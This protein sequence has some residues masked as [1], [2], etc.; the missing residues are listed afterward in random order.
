MDGPR[1]LSRWVKYV[2][3]RKTNT[4]YV[5]CSLQFNS[6]FQSYLTLWPH[7]LQYVRF[8]CP[9]WTP[10]PCSNS[11]PLSQ[12]WH[13]TTSSS[14]DPFFSHLQSFPASGSFQMS[15]LFASGGQRNG[16]SASA[17]DL[18]MNI[19]DWFPLGWTGWI[20]LQSKGLSR[21]Q[22][23]FSTPQFK[24]INSLVLSFPY[25]PPL[26][27]VEIKA[28]VHSDGNESANNAG[29]AHS[30]PW[31]GMIP[32]RGKWQHSPVFLPGA[33]PRQKNILGYSPRDHRESDVTEWL[34]LSHIYHFCMESK[35]DMEELIHKTK[36]D[37]Q[38]WRTDLWL[39][40][41]RGQGKRRIGRFV[42]EKR[43]WKKGSLLSHVGLSAMPWNIALQ[44]PLSIWLP[45]IL[46]AKILAW[47]HSLL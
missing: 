2:R 1:D 29:E 43:K 25:S 3:K 31:V 16:V 13:P 23:S 11:C 18:P 44:S 8:P 45:G 9:S 42:V 37:A 7:G 33:S 35:H 41:G 30:I 12:W 19:Q 5:T 47:V 28:M 34:W 4:I 39:P 21:Y 40:S 27:S 17:S 36:T 46:Q 20:S 6:V 26:I 10:R 15:H 38:R 14:V 22:G 24:G 32:W